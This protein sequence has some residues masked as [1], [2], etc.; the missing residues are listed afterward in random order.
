MRQK[1]VKTYRKVMQLYAS[2]FQF[3]EPYQLIVDAEFCLSIAHQ[4]LDFQPRLEDVTQGTVKP[5]ITQCCIQALYDKGEAG[6]AAVE[7]AKGFERRKC[8]HFK[9]RPQDECVTSIVA[10]TDNKH[11]YVVATQSPELRQTLRGI[12]GVPIIYLSRSVVL[13]EAPSNATLNRK[14]QMENAKLHAPISEL[15][16]LKSIPLPSNST[17]LITAGLPLASSSALPSTGGGEE[18]DGEKVEPAL[19]KRKKKGP[20]GPNPLSVKKKKAVGPA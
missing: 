2:T 13:L 8:N 7:L 14:K 17:S 18:A 15:A 4:K 12:P 16:A 3:R 19:K 5:L 6:Q 20:K 9:P 10:G 11:R 1:R